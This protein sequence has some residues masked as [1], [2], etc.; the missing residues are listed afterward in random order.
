MEEGGSA[1]RSKSPV[2]TPLSQDTPGATRSTRRMPEPFCRYSNF[3][4][5]N[6]IVTL[7]HF[8][9]KV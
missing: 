1:V 4:M 8:F 2:G 6:T 5:I 9:D 7:I 3:T